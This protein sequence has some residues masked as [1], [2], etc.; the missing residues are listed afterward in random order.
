M[1]QQKKGG[2]L[3]GLGGHGGALVPKGTDVS[4]YANIAFFGLENSTPIEYNEEIIAIM[5]SKPFAV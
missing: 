3:E 5:R 1:M 4:L 2:G